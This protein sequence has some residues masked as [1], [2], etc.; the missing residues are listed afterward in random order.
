[1][2][3]HFKQ[4]ERELVKV[5]TFFKKQSRK[6]IAEGKLGEEHIVETPCLSKRSKWIPG[7]IKALNETVDCLQH[8]R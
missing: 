1:M 6:L 7:R 3:K 5:A 4:N 8:C 2:N